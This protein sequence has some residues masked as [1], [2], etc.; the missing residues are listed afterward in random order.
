VGVAE[1][2]AAAAVGDAGAVMSSRR[3]PPGK[4][5]KYETKPGRRA[6]S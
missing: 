2:L 5:R 4:A 3:P 1:R 6:L